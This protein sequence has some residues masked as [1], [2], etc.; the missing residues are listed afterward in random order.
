MSPL[1][2]AYFNAGEIFTVCILGVFLFFIFFSFSE[3]DSILEKEDFSNVAIKEIY[4]LE[5]DAFERN[6]QYVNLEEL[7]GRS[8]VLEDF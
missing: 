1:R 6:G 2:F 7:I 4:R 8:N 3:A 5:M